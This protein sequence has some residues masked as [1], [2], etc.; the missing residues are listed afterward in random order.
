[1]EVHIEAPVLEKPPGDFLKGSDGVQETHIA[2]LGEHHLAMMEMD[3]LAPFFCRLVGLRRWEH[4][5]PSGLWSFLP[6]LAPSEVVWKTKL[7]NH[8]LVAG[9][10]R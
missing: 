9:V 2:S 7:F 5:Y 10:F 8:F 4:S 3:P 6:H 1:M